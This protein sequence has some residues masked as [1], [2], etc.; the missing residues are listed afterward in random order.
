MLT[1]EITYKLPSGQIIYQRLIQDATVLHDN[2]AETFNVAGKLDG[3]ELTFNEI[4]TFVTNRLT[5]HYMQL[6]T[7]LEWPESKIPEVVAYHKKDVLKAILKDYP[8]ALE[9][10]K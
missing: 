8:K 7:V 9:F 6:V 5:S 4:D 3:K 2:D 1:Q 10:L